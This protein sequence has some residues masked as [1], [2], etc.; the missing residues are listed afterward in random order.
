[1]PYNK[2]FFFL[3]FRYRRFVAA[4]NGDV[5]DQDLHLSNVKLIN[6]KD[7]QAAATKAAQ[8]IT[9]PKVD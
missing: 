6:S 3:L 4:S 8:L 1:M 5:H 2:S 7:L 9:I